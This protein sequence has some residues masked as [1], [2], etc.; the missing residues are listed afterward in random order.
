MRVLGSEG[1][2]QHSHTAVCPVSDCHQLNLGIHRTVHSH[3]RSVSL[4]FALVS[5][6]PELTG[7]CGRHY[8]FVKLKL[9]FCGWYAA[10][11]ACIV[12]FIGKYPRRPV[13]YWIWH[14]YLYKSGGYELILPQTPTGSGLWLDS[15]DGA[16]VLKVIP[17]PCRQFV[18]LLIVHPSRIGFYVPLNVEFDALF[19][20]IH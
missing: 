4:S 5:T 10:K 20:S 1:N 19:G 16:G 15:C 8:G 2:S 9:L 11:S 6:H 17:L 14:L 18:V 7:R 3:T 12:H 13:V